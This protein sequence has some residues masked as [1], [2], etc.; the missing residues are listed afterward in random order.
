MFVP[1]P[2]VL[3]IVYGV[4]KTGQACAIGQSLLSLHCLYTQSRSYRSNRPLDKSA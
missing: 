1:A 3:V 4:E 2:K